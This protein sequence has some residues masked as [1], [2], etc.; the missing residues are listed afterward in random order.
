MPKISTEPPRVRLTLCA[1]VEAIGEGPITRGD[2][3]P[4][5]MRKGQRITGQS[6]LRR[7]FRTALGP[8]GHIARFHAAHPQRSAI[9]VV[10][11]GNLGLNAGV[12]AWKDGEWL[13]V[14]GPEGGAI[15]VDD[16]G[17]GRRVAGDDEPEDGWVITGPGL[18][19]DGCPAV[20]D[21]TTFADPRHRLLFPYVTTEP[22]ARVDFGHDILLADPDLYRSAAAHRPVRLPITDVAHE[23][24]LDALAVKGYA[25]SAQPGRPGTYDIDGDVLEI[26]FFPG[27]YPHHALAVG[28]DGAVTS[29]IV[30]GLSNRAG[31]SIDA[32]AA[33][34]VAHGARDAILLDNGGDVGLWRA[35]SKQWTVR[36][37]EPDREDAWP[38]TACLVYSTLTPP[39]EG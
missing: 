27:L 33:Q 11:C 4:Y 9:A 30:P 22:G 34:L 18:V 2:G 29:W 25:A 26:V 16:E 10:G 35:D 6:E 7:G 23:A 14:A 5:L 13:G 20:S 37:T 36:P 32:L 21:V 39:G 24:L 8:E 38:L 19:R 12:R 31:T 3:P 1:D 28:A 15:A 17:R